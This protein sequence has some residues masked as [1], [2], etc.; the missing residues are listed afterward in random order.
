MVRGLDLEGTPLT[1]LS[2]ILAAGG[3]YQVFN[4]HCG[5]ES[6]WVPVSAVSPS[7]LVEE[8]ETTRKE[9]EQDRTPILPAPPLGLDGGS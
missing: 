7:L 8:I 3:D 1:S 2:K 4:G 6:G 9:K 5:A